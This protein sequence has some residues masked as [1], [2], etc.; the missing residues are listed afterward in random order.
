MENIKLSHDE[1][2]IEEYAQF[3]CNHVGFEL[4]P[5]NDTM[6]AVRTFRKKMHSVMKQYAEHMVQQ[7]LKNFQF[8][9]ANM[10]EPLPSANDHKEYNRGIRDGVILIRN[11][12]IN[13]IN[14]DD[15]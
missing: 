11:A 10:C 14:K 7:E 12:V 4:N 15:E 8:D 9:V 1:K 2:K 5:S 13:L 6:I 3:F